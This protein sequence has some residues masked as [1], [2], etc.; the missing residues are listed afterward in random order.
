LATIFVFGYLAFKNINTTFF[1]NIPSRII[2]V[3]A[4]YPGA[5]PEEIEEGITLK[6]EDNLKGLTGVDRVTS[7]SRE[8]FAQI[9]VELQTGQDANVLLQEVK[10]AVDQV[11]SFPVGM[12]QLKVYKMEPRDFAIAFAISGDVDLKTLKTYARRAERDL[13]AIEGISKI[14]LSG[15]PDEEIEIS[16][17]ENK[18]RAYNLTFSEVARAV[19]NANVKI[20]GGKIKGSEE[21][22]LI[23]ANNK[24]Y[25]AA[26]L[27]NHIIKSTAD[28]VIIRL[29]DVAEIK[30]KWSEDPNR[31]YFNGKPSVTVDVQ[32]TND[33]DLFYVAEKTKEYIDKFNADH[34]DVQAFVMRDGS[35]IIQERIDVLTS[36]GVIGIF[37]VVLF[38][39][40]SLNPRVSF[41]VALAI[42]LAFAGMF[43][44]SPLYGLTINVMS[45][46]AMILVIGILVDD[47]IVIGENIY[48]HY[49]AGAKP[50][51]A[52]VKGTIEVL[53][54]VFSAIMTTVVI[55]MTFFFLEGHLGD[56]AKDMGFVVA[57]TL[58]I[59]L[60]EGVF[61]LPAHI[62][63][64]KALRTPVSKHSWIERHSEKTLFWFRD[65]I[66]GP[67]LRFCIDNTIIAVA[68]SLA[69]FFITIGALKGSVIK[70]TFFPVLEF[71]NV[72]VTLEM[73][74]GT[75]DYITDN[76]LIDMEAS[77]KKMHKE[78]KEK[79]NGEDFITSIS[80]SVGP[81]THQGGLR[82]NFTPG[83][84]R[85]LSGMQIQNLIRRHIGKVE[86]VVK[87]Q[88]GGG[89]HWGMP[90]SVSI[91]SN[92]L[93]QLRLAKEKLKTELKKVDKLKD[94]NDN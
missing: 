59:S 22:L 19:K 42:P 13:L 31:T 41:W 1:P 30:D 69:L 91:K 45:L 60:V 27:E 51:E 21:E 58:I 73:P 79:N 72:R 85:E 44:F 62:A 29:K 71:D 47:G 7:V 24:G 8:N 26:D 76:L 55:F 15:F 70:T 3:T 81:A 52:A 67:A 25:Y 33:E 35:R 56:R 34:E 12:E 80:R 37:L 78:N 65:K 89:G 90:V 66:Y 61:I 39:S 50:I 38:L 48:Q 87:L 63:H 16:F 9:T 2:I 53:P 49:E 17:Q 68:V 36:N 4:S 6:I 46:M 86:N 75:R 43:M 93:E 14:N 20:T 18:L 82:V 57:A 5:S 54:A 11:S 23:R 83:E 40:L 64:S 28:G 10:N 94:V 74:A 77:I 84:D 32:K 92:N 88:V